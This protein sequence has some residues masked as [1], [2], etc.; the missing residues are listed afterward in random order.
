MIAE[1][2]QTLPAPITTLAPI[3]QQPRA[4]QHP[5]AV[6]L[7]GLRPGSRR[8]MLAAVNEIAW[9]LMTGALPTGE[10]TSEGRPVQDGAAQRLDW[11]AVRYQH[12]QAIR[13]A[14][15]SR[16]AFATANKMLSALRG[17]L[18]ECWRLGLTAAEDYY[19]AIDLKRVKG[20]SL[21]RGRAL[22][23]GEITAL[24][25]VCQADPS[26]LGARDGA[27]FAVLWS[28]GLR[29]SEAAS[30]QLEHYDV[31]TGALTVRNGKGGKDRLVYL[32]D[33]ASA[34]AMSDWLE[35]RGTEP[36]PLYFAGVRNGKVVDGVG[37][38]S[39]ALWCALAKR[40][41]QAKVKPFSP[42]DLRRTFISELLDA[43]ADISTV[44]QLAGHANV[45]T[46]QRYDR[47]GEE[48]KR[49]A[50]SMLHLPYSGRKA[51]LA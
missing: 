18:K 8:G 21:L 25:N 16:Y 31:E 51:A 44:Q 39:Q 30:L 50:A 34:L 41:K 5:V 33:P 1:S 35:V 22:S 17:V 20:E 26:D 29:R 36:G 43:G 42:H 6:Y 28:C 4:D 15:A 14:L 7:G 27:I 3:A 2:I 48:T 9:Y 11:S 13:Q 37:I 12:T 38:T 46:T 40:M 19:R 49:K 10:K 24:C 45:T 47:R 23:Y 32:A